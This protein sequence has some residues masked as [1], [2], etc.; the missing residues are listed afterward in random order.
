MIASNSPEIETQQQQHPQFMS[1]TCADA[2]H[3]STGIREIT[4]RLPAYYRL[5]PS[6]CNCPNDQQLLRLFVVYPNSLSGSTVGRLLG[7][8]LDFWQRR[9]MPRRDVGPG[10]EPPEADQL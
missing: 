2:V 1:G 8:V 6:A 10:T 4:L 5:T 9:F 7:S 3:L